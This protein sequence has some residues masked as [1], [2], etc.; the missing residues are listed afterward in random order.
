MLTEATIPTR[1]FWS[2]AA[3]IPTTK[4]DAI[5][6]H[7]KIEI[8]KKVETVETA[9]VRLLAMVK[10]LLSCDDD[11]FRNIL[12]WPYQIHERVSPTLRTHVITLTFNVVEL[13][14]CCGKCRGSHDPDSLVQPQVIRS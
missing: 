14:G 6:Q 8:E 7:V 5:T 4:S 9:V 1:L 2:V 11:S 12:R 13:D 10:S 3:L